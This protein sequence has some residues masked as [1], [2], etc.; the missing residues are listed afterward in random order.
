MNKQTIILTGRQS[1]SASSPSPSFPRPCPRIQSPSI[2]VN[3][4]AFA[5]VNELTFVAWIKILTSSSMRRGDCN[6]ACF[7][8]VSI[9]LA[10]QLQLV[11][12]PLTCHDLDGFV[13]VLVGIHLNPFPIWVTITFCGS[14]IIKTSTNLGIADSTRRHGHLKSKPVL[15]HSDVEHISISF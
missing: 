1:R 10:S 5:S 12:N 14:I 4:R 3:K 7:S 15:R 9:M 6:T 8:M 11:L 2:K 13:E